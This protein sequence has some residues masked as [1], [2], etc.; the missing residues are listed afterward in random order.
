M[1]YDLANS[2]KSVTLLYV[3]ILCYDDLTVDPRRVGDGS[4][5]FHVIKIACKLTDL[6]IHRVILLS[7]VHNIAVV[8]PVED[9]KAFRVLRKLLVFPAV[10]VKG[11]LIQQDKAVACVVLTEI[12]EIDLIASFYVIVT[13]DT[14]VFA[15]TFGNPL[16]FLRR[17][18][19]KHSGFATAGQ[20]EEAGYHR[21]RGL[22]VQSP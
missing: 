18:L 17:Y 10:G 3:G 22:V 15:L 19:R 20:T 12:G 21:L 7:H 5:A 11:D 6:L 13:K 9:E 1:K 16:K 14:L 8:F 2:R 4:G